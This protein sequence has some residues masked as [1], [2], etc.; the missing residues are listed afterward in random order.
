[1]WTENEDNNDNEK[2]KEWELN[3]LAAKVKNTVT[4][5]PRMG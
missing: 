2:C 3:L 5:Q 4:L 1:L